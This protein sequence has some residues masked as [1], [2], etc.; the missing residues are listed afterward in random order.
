[1]FSI[2]KKQAKEVDTSRPIT[3]STSNAPSVQAWIPFYDISNQVIWRRDKHIVS[4]IY[5]GRRNIFLLSDKEK[6]NAIHQLFEVINSL[7]IYHVFQSIQRP[8]DLDAY[9]EE[10]ERMRNEETHFMRRRILDSSIRSS[11]RIASSGEA[12]DLHY[13][14]FLVSPVNEKNPALEIQQLLSTTI[15]L[16]ESLTAAEIESHICSNQELR[17]VNFTFLNP[18]HAGFEHAPENSLLQLPP[19][20]SLEVDYE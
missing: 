10:Q 14:V 15:E 2:K 16:A 7:N 13:Y 12:M 9:I 11:S 4:G 6:K 18:K 1:M 3:G 8:V 20:F 5:T 19:Q 17:E